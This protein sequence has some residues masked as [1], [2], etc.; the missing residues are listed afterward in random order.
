MP[1]ILPYR[2]RARTGQA[3]GCLLQLCDAD[4]TAPEEPAYRV[5]S[6]LTPA[7][8]CTGLDINAAVAQPWHPAMP[9]ARLAT[10]PVRRQ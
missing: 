3:V 5:L 7:H 9:P 10:A 6:P 8:M 4:R 2:Y 1:T